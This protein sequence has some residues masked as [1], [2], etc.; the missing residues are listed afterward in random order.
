MSPAENRA[1]GAPAPWLTL[2]GIGEDGLDGLSLLA[3]RALEEAGRIFGGTRHAELVTALGKSVTP[4]P[5]PF[6][7]GVGMLLAG[8]GTPTVVL[9]SGDPMWFGVGATLSRALAPHEMLV[10]PAPSSLSLA[11]ARLGWPLQESEILSLHGR[12]L[13]LLRGVLFP[14]ARILCLTS[15]ANAAHEISDLLTDEGYGAS[16]ITVLEHLGGPRE[17]ILA[18]TAESWRGAVAA[19]NVVAIE[20]KAVANT[21]LRA[22][23]PGLADDA[24]RHDGKITKREIRAVTLARLMPVPGALLWD[25]GAGSGAVAIEW[26]RAAP[27]SQ[28]VGLEP[29][30]ARRATARANAA[31]LGVPHLDLRAASAPDGLAGLPAPD[32][33]FFGGGLTAPG[34][35]EAALAALKPG[36]RLVAN[37]VTLESEAVLAAAHARHGG[38][39]AR[40]AVSR[41]GPVGG[42]TGWRPLMPVTQWSLTLP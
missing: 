25:I 1:S 33:I 10:L 29:D 15:G 27:R 17:R 30:D 35:L 14:G 3:R 41:A 2:I 20:A 6:E 23:V 22:R 9:A 13:D 5:S 37:A 19:L 32:A 21:P 28:A 34:A 31:A 7:A 40:I 38:E 12:P 8:R 42:M 26:L 11:A 24:F 18:A 4:W 16:R 36:G 39:L